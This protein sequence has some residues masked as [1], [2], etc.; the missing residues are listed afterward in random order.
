MSIGRSGE[1]GRSLTPMMLGCLPPRGEEKTFSKQKRDQKE[2][3]A[4][5]ILFQGKLIPEESLMYDFSTEIE[6][7]GM[8]LP[9]IFAN[10]RGETGGLPSPGRIGASGCSALR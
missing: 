9:I 7:E 4:I 1:K 10:Y 3:V 6:G 5:F 8:I 2:E